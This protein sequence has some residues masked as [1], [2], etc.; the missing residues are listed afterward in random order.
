MNRQQ[1]APRRATHIRILAG[2]LDRGAGSHVYHYQLARHLAMRGY[3]VSV[4]AFHSEHAPLSGVEIQSVRI[5]NFSN[6][7]VVWRY[8]SV[9]RHW[10]CAQE[11]RTSRAGVPDVVIGGEHLWLKG[12]RRRF[13]KIP[14]IYLPHSL[15]VRDEIDS[16]GLEGV[17]RDAT[18]RVYQRIQSWALSTADCILRFTKAG[19]RSLKSEYPN[20]ALSP[21]IVNE[22]GIDVP[23]VVAR[24]ESSG[25]LR[26]LIVGRLIF[27]KGIDLA[28]D[29]LAHLKE[30]PW[31]LTI[32]GAG[33]EREALERQVRR[34]GLDDRVVFAGSTECPDEW[35][36]QSDLLLFPSRSESLGLVALEAMG[37]GTPCLAF[38]P[39]GTEFRTVSDEFITHGNTG[40]LANSAE[41]FTNILRSVLFERGK[42]LELGR[43]ARQEVLR[44]YS[45]EAHLS[46]YEQIFEWLKLPPPRRTLTS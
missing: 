8:A 43:L 29:S 39:N 9:L 33:G 32:V 45:W 17:Q 16:S 10:Y 5:P 22:I 3:Q 4:M 24:R 2:R 36:L 31:V 27:S 14:W 6:L 28:L 41:E 26:L 23:A 18:L 7:P 12:S 42:L 34:L 40:L 35:Y 30:S 21:L 44:R 37:H 38:K 19:C 15:T 11:V 13:P 20:V 46:K 25:P 1:Y